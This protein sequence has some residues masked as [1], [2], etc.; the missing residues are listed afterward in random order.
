MTPLVYNVTRPTCVDCGRP[1]DIRELVTREARCWTHFQ[2]TQHPVDL[3]AF[4]TPDAAVTGPT[5]QKRRGRPATGAAGARGHR[6][7][8]GGP[9]PAAPSSPR[10]LP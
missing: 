5:V 2:Q 8:A 3:A 4:F 7:P 1:A 9:T 10:C 6:S